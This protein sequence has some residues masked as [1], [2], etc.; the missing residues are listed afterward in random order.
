MPDLPTLPNSNILQF[1]LWLMLPCWKVM[2]NQNLA[3]CVYD[4]EIRSLRRNSIDPEK[5]EL[6]AWSLDN[7]KE[8]QI[9]MTNVLTS[10]CLTS[11]AAVEKLTGI[12]KVRLL[13][14]AG[15]WR[16]RRVDAASIVLAGMFDA[17]VVI[18]TFRS[19]VAFCASEMG[20]ITSILFIFEGIPSLTFVFLFLLASCQWWRLLN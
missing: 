7:I 19:I 16:H 4:A 6:Q 13:T 5:E 15:V 8:N 12:P 20:H 14:D 18:F 3:D 10:F 1:I 9:S 2:M 11:C 17:G